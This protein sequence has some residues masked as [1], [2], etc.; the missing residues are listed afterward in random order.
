MIDESHPTPTE[1]STAPIERDHRQI[2]ATQ[3]RAEQASLERFIK[4]FTDHPDAADKRMKSLTYRD[5]RDYGDA[6]AAI[7]ALQRGEPVYQDLQ[8]VWD[9]LDQRREAHFQIMLNAANKGDEEARK[10]NA[11]LAFSFGHMGLE[12]QS[13]MTPAQSNLLPIMI[14]IR[15]FARSL[16]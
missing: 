2:V 5:H 9:T 7:E 4:E 1:E 14:G 8:N 15:R 16:T 13:S 3:L 12:I 10:T 11:A 6:A